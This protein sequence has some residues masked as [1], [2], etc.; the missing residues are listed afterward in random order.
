MFTLYTVLL[1]LHILLVI[2]WLGAGITTT[3]ISRQC[4][5][6]TAWAPLLAPLARKWF[7]ITSGLTGLVGI[8]LWIDGP[9][10]FGELWILLAAAGWFISSGIGSTQLGPKVEKWAETGD[11]QYFDAYMK[12]APID[13]GLLVLIVVDMVMKPGL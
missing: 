12:L 11:R 10:G 6:D 3:V 4:N 8:L 2:C 13:L 1:T 5:G 9:Y 7:P